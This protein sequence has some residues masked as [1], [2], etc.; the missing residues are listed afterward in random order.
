MRCAECGTL[1]S[2][3]NRYCSNCGAH[4]IPEGGTAETTGPWVMGHGGDWHGP[5]EDGPVLA[6]R[7]GGPQGALYPVST[8]ADVSIG[9]SPNADVFLDDVT[10]S[11][12]HA[13]IIST[14][15]GLVL[16]DLGSLNGTYVN[17][18]RIEDDE[19]LH[20]GDEV[21]IGKFRLT[22]IAG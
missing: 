20:D 6:V 2:E 11:R 3:G 22:F 19:L 17:R 8:D 21:Q 7:S 18:R 10:V 13:R 16:R 12:E 5:H 15:G 4:L 14:P 9:R 1:Q